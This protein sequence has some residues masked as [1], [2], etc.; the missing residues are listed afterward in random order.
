MVR[1]VLA[2]LLVL[3]S[4]LAQAADRKTFT[5]GVE[6][7]KNWLPY[8]EVRNGAYGGPTCRMP[9]GSGTCRPT[10]TREWWRS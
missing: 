9:L 2:S 10:N 5:V 8:S 3:V 6:D 7:Y 1:A 4:C